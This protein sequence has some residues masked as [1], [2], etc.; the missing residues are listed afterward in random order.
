MHPGLT[1]EPLVA[2]ADPGRS[3]VSRPALRAG[4][5]GIN[6]A[7]RKK[8]TPEQVGRKLATAEREAPRDKYTIWIAV[9][10]GLVLPVLAY[11]TSPLHGPPSVRNFSSPGQQASRSPLRTIG[12]DRIL[13]R[14]RAAGSHHL[15]LADGYDDGC[16]Q[17]ERPPAWSGCTWRL[18]CRA[19]RSVTLILSV[20]NPADY[21]STRG[22][23]IAPVGLSRTAILARSSS[24]LG[25]GEVFAESLIAGG[26]TVLAVWSARACRAVRPG[27]R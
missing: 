6:T 4:R 9:A 22:S 2:A 16:G 23:V 18:H 14:V 12:Y 7:T 3:R 27:F 26:V 1:A 25:S 10:P 15:M 24:R 17:G 21:V 11:G 8:H 19:S 13:S 5:P 20:S